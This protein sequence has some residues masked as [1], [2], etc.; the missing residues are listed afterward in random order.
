MS[1]IGQFRAWI[2]EAIDP[3]HARVDSLEERMT[4]VEE[5]LSPA[6][7]AVQQ[8]SAR[9]APLKA[10]K[11]GPAKGKGAASEPGFPD[12]EFAPGKDA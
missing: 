2:A 8:A 10:V 6:S 1:A 5:R 3:L 4:A 11:P 7:A 9:K 12:E